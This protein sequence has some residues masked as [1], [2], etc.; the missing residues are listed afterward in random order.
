VCSLRYKRGLGK[1]KNAD[2]WL[3]PAALSVGSSGQEL[4]RNLV[5]DH[6]YGF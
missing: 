6:V 5:K 2:S 1:L 4:Q 3:V